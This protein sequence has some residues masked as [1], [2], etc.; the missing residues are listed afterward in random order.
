MT[1][2]E[3]QIY[4]NNERE[5]YIYK[6]ENL[7][8]GK[9][10]IGKRK[11]PDYLTPEGDTGYMGSGVLLKQAFQ[12]YGKENFKKEIVFDKIYLESTINFLEKEFIRIFREHNKAEYNIASGGEGVMTGRHH[13]EETRKKLSEAHKNISA[14]TRK[15]MSEAE[16]GEKNHFF[17]KHHTEEA[18]K[19]M[20][21]ALKGKKFTEEHKQRLSE[22]QKGNKNSLGYIHTE[23]TKRKNSEAHKGQ[24][25]WN[26][27]KKLKSLSEK[28]CK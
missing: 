10:Y 7:I 21:E 17:G 6:I 18:R 4:D 25:P 27:G 12:K 9:N 24:T 3:N 11:C 15:K 8:N 5:F 1:E 20:S 14:E 23:E 19:K 13:T 16:K 28:L 26:K 2:N 22:A